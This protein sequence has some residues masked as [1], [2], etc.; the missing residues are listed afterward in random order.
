VDAI[1]ELRRS[2]R[3][4]RRHRNLVRLDRQA[5]RRRD[6]IETIPIHGWQLARRDA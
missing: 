5:P 2:T 6:P 1:A 4:A 3:A